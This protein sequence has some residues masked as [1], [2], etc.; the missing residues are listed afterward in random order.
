VSAARPV[1][2]LWLVAGFGLWS[3]ALVVVYAFHAIGCAFGFTPTGLRLGIGLVTLGHVL[4]LF[5]LV[6]RLDRRSP[7]GTLGAVA[8]WTIAAALVA[9]IVTFVPLLALTTCT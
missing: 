6:R 7:P 8:R 4:A 2:L 9:T 3:S 5:A 1:H